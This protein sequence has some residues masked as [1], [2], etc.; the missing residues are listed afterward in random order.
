MPLYE[1]LVGLLGNCLLKVE[2]DILKIQY[3]VS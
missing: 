3:V 2:A 1:M